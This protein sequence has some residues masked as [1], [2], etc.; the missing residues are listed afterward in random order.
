MDKSRPSTKLDWN[1]M[2]GFEQIAGD[3]E[4]IRDQSSRML[5]PKVGQKVGDKV[6]L[7]LGGKV[8][9]KLGAKTGL[10]A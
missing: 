3:R 9:I 10:K 8:G 6:G 2:L 4:S 1:R 5:S 7:K